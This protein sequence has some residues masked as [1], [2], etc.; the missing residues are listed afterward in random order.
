VLEDVE[1]V[2]DDPGLRGVPLLEGGLAGR[3]PHVHHGP[4]DLAAFRRARPGEELVQDRLGAVLSAEPDRP[5]PLQVAD[6]DAVAVAP[7]DGEPV[8]ADDPRRGAAGPAEL[9]PH[10]LLVQL[11]DGLPI[12]GELLGDGC[13]GALSTPPPHVES[14]PLGLALKQA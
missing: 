10:V 13:D 14:E 4:A 2:V 8:D 7:A 12:E 6:D 5:P 9:L 11:L 1:L 3:L